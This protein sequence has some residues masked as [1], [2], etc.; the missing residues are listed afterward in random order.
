MRYCVPIAKKIWSHYAYA[1]K[2]DDYDSGTPKRQP[3]VHIVRYHKPQLQSTDTFYESDVLGI[4]DIPI[5]QTDA[6]VGSN[7]VCTEA[8]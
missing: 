3:T 1:V 7:V 4:S 5:E 6:N 8:G 2:P